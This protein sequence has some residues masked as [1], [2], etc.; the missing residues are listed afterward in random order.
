MAKNFTIAVAVII[1]VIAGFFIW[2][3]REVSAPTVVDDFYTFG[4][5]NAR[6]KIP[7]GWMYATNE[8]REYASFYSPDFRRT[9]GSTDTF[10][11][12]D[13]AGIAQGAVIVIPLFFY[14]EA[15]PLPLG[16]S[17]SLDGEPGDIAEGIANEYNPPILFD[18]VRLHSDDTKYM[19]IS[20]EY[21]EGFT[22]AGAILANFIE[23]FEFLE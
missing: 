11:F 19:I 22:E 18:R 12:R 23:S 10:E 5:L 3:N 7:S 13:G 21:S 16:K 1:L 15:E 14:E 20:L 9:D 2:E 17:I 8:S 6:A 4:T